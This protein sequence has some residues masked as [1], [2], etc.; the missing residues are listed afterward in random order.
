MPWV[1]MRRYM[2][3]EKERDLPSVIPPGEEPLALVILQ[4][5]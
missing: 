4:E 1:Q 3:K 5:P 2:E